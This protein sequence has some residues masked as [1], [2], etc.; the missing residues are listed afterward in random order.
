MNVVQTMFVTPAEHWDDN[1]K[2]V[3]II[4][5]HKK[6]AKKNPDSYRGV[7]LLS[8]ISRILARVLTTRFRNWSRK[9]GALGDNQDCFKQKRS[10]ADITQIIVSLHEDSR[11]EEEE[12]RYKACL[13][14]LRKL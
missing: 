11:R 4:P 5:L 8:M 6:G 14:D 9:F 2:V 13:L 3:L 12:K 7:C 10:T 1:V